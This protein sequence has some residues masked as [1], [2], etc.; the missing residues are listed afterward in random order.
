MGLS[1]GGRGGTPSVGDRRGG[2]LS[3]VAGVGRCVS[4]GRTGESRTHGIDPA[5]GRWTDRH[6]G[7]GQSVPPTRPVV[8]RQ[9]SVVSRQSSVASSSVV[10]HSPVVSR[11]SSVV[12][13]R[14]IVSRQSS[15]VSH[16]S[17][18]RSVTSRSAMPPQTAG[19]HAQL[20]SEVTRLTEPPPEKLPSGDPAVKTVQPPA[21][22]GLRAWLVVLVSFLCNGVIFGIVNCYGVLLVAFL[23]K[24]EAAGVANAAF[25]CCEYAFRATDCVRWQGLLTTGQGR[26]VWGLKLG[27]GSDASAQKL[28]P[29]S[30]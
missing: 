14:L 23:E 8:S 10:S 21:D 30:N 27:H 25:K 3:S 2:G 17:V 22:G 1:V 5:P 18:S 7:R 24:M 12:T 15:V 9:S 19:R 29:A 4:S 20:P 16:S 26:C 11:Q 28:P 6:T 13:S